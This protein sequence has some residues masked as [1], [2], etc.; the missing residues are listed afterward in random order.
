VQRPA[1]RATAAKQRPSG[2]EIF[3]QDVR[4]A[5]VEAHGNARI[6]TAGE[7]PTG[8]DADLPERK[9]KP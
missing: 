6:T 2:K 4:E 1:D 9:L 7:T 5:P 3:S 8:N